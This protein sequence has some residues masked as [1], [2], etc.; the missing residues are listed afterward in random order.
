M[1]FSP[2]STF[3][4]RTIAIIL[5]IIVALAVLA[6]AISTIMICY[7][8]FMAI[9]VDIKAFGVALKWGATFILSFAIASIVIHLVDEFTSD[10]IDFD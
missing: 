5:W 3:L 7:N 6:L 8:L 2:D 1:R 10:I 9:W 4:E